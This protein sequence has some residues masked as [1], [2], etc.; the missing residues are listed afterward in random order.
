ML[1]AGADPYSAGPENPD[2]E[3]TPEDSG[4]SALAFAA[5]YGHFEVFQQKQL[6]LDVNHPALRLVAQYSCSRKGMELLKLLFERGMEVNDQENG[7]CSIL[8]N[9]LERMSLNLRF[10]QSRYR[11]DGGLLDTPEAK[12]Q[13]DVIEFLV[14]HGAR[15]VPKDTSELNSTRRSLLK[16]VPRFTLAF[17]SIMATNKACTRHDIQSLLGTPTMKKHLRN[18]SHLVTKFI[19]SFPDGH[20]RGEK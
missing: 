8:Q 5:L 6:R 7:G 11:I 14:K 17:F 2:A 18:Q 10:D 1:W 19:A 4:C 15:W 13:I 9:A 12:E 16:L 20:Q 3:S